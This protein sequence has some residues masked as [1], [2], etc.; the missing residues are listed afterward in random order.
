MNKQEYLLN[1]LSQECIEVA[2][3][4]SKALEFGLEDIYLE[5]NPNK[6]QLSNKERIEHELNDLL[7]TLDLILKEK[8]LTERTITC[9]TGRTNKIKKIIKYMKYSRT[10][11]ALK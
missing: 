7:G 4:I 6:P 3:E 1:K 5:Y 11:G 9:Q 10:T 8:M 2:K